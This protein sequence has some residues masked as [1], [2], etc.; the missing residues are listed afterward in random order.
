M[1]I[2]E[3]STGHNQHVEKKIEAIKKEFKNKGK[4]LVAFSG[5]VDSSVLA[6]IGFLSL[7]DDCIAVTAVSETYPEWELR[8]AKKI[9]EEIGIRHYVIKHSEL[10]ADGF[11]ENSPDRCY[12]CKRSLFKRLREFGKELGF[13][14]IAEGTN[15]SELSGH[16][17]GYRAVKEFDVFTPL[18]NYT[19]EEIREIAQ[20]LGLSNW[21]KPSMACL[22][23]RFPFGEK[24]TLEKLEKIEKAE[25][26]LFSLGVETCR[27]RYHR[28]IAR[29]EVHPGDFKLMVNYRDAIVS[30]FKSLGFKFI[31]MDLEGFRSGSLSEDMK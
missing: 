23:S 21:N 10:S 30:Y 2:A 25:K 1:Q 12:I 6:K 9:A 5:G 3:K 14:V 31:T 29:I 20:Y 19:K 28:E 24:I 22:S 7:G 16:R 4:V 18:K 8:Y 17:P 27:V 11:S 15:K 26:F 13:T